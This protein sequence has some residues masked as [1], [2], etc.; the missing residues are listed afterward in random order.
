MTVAHLDRRRKTSLLNLDIQWKRVKRRGSPSMVQPRRPVVGPMTDSMMVEM[1]DVSRSR[2]S[3][4]RSWR[5]K[6]YISLIFGDSPD[7]KWW[8]ISTPNEMRSPCYTIECSSY[9]ITSKCSLLVSRLA[10]RRSATCKL[11]SVTCTFDRRPI[12]QSRPLGRSADL[13]FSFWTTCDER[14]WV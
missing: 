11:T 14:I 8:H 9:S 13:G 4:D 7:R 1:R 6:V 2:A 10:T 12:D 5:E 3:N